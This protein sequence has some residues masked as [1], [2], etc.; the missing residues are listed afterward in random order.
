LNKRFGREANSP[1]FEIAGLILG[2]DHISRFTQTR[3][4]NAM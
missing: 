1:R 3:I 2:F 4:T